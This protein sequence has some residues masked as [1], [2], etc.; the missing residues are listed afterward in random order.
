MG[1]CAHNLKCKKTRKGQHE[2]SSGKKVYL[3]SVVSYV[4]VASRSRK[5]KTDGT[6][7]GLSSEWLL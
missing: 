5:I 3:E 1:V 4:N 6:S 7:I 2:G